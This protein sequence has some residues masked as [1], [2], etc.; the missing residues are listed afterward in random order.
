ML[1][2]AAA[3]TLFTLITVQC[4]ASPLVR[5]ET[6]RTLP[7]GWQQ[8]HRAPEN[9]VL[10]LRIGLAQS[11]VDRLEEL[12][13]DVSHPE[14]QNYGKHWSAAKVA[15][16]FRP[17]SETIDIV[18][19]WLTKEG[20]I[21]SRVRLSASGGWIEANVTV[22]EA[23]QLLQTEYYVYQHTTSDA[24]YISCAHSGYSVPEHVAGH[25]ELVTPTI[26]F[27]VITKAKRQLPGKHPG[28]PGFRSRS[29]HVKGNFEVS[30]HWIV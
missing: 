2:L 3:L 7:S 25:V 11:N 4:L 9:A 24:T 16:T 1:L 18:R 23:E 10:P 30:T 28:R 20:I 8:A 26:H 12:L 21:A 19:N 5:H 17:S 14:S 6:R 22:A 27:D 15:D 13:L 29:P